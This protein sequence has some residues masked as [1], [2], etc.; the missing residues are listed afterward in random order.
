M[1]FIACQAI[2]RRDRNASALMWAV[3]F[4]A[5]GTNTGSARDGQ[6]GPQLDQYLSFAACTRAGQIAVCWR[7][8]SDGLSLLG[9]TLSLEARHSA[10][11]D[12]WQVAVLI[13]LRAESV[14]T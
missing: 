4:W 10:Y 12:A 7:C 1:D 6:S 9:F 14:D 11:I 3:A 2:C 13:A 8:A 5:A